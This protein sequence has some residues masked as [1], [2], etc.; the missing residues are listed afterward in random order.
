M[1]LRV[2]IAQL[3]LL[4]GD[5]AG[6]CSRIL[7]TAE[8]ARDDL[9]A[10][11]VV[12][13]ELGISG[14]PPE[15]LLLRTD[16]LRQCRSAVERLAEKAVNVCMVVGFPE[17]ADGCLYNSA[18]VLQEGRIAAVYRKCRLPNYGVFDEKRYFSPGNEPCLFQVGAVPLAVTLCEDIWA[19]GIVEQS[20]MAGAQLILNLNA[21]PF[22][23][24]KGA[25]REAVLR[26]RIRV[27]R[28]PIIYVNQVGG[29]DE[30]VFDGS[31]F[32]MGADGEVCY[33]APEFEE[34]TGVVEFGIGESLSPVYGGIASSYAEV[35]S[36]YKALVLGIRDYVRKNGFQGAVLG[37]S[38]GID[39]ALTLALAADALGKDQVEVVLMPSR[40]TACMSN[41]DAVAQAQCLGVQYHVIP[42]EP[43]VNIFT[44]M[45]ED[46]FRGLPVDTTE[47]NIQARCRGLLLMALSNKKRRLLLTT[48]NKSEMSVGYATLYGDMAGGFA[49]LKDVPKMLVYRLVEYRNCLS[50]VIPQRVIERPPSAELAS[51]QVDEDSLPPYSILDAILELYVEQDCSIEEII[52]EG[53]DAVDV[54]K[55]VRLV[56][57]NEYKR[58]QA[59]PGVRITARA[60]G[61]DRRYP[62]TSGFRPC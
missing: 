26:D 8:T 6:N 10:D 61:R 1:K 54:R 7:C 39:S 32:V 28:V 19:E 12:F 11:L 62:M 57:M 40:Y 23:A 59:P 56:N 30:L 42:I 49:P 52:G 3:N 51:D 24:N 53:Y 5:I 15:D 58:R 48:G 47:E 37:L 29:Q 25:E 20:S 55:L 44:D 60:F 27:A 41:E 22:H 9:G 46:T 33:R 50:Q 18:A 35:S 17:A 31:S 4:V 45:L 16:F 14:Y 34:S 13:S 43:A 2:A 21:S 36:E 38:G